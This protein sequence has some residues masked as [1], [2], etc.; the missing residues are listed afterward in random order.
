MAGDDFLT[1]TTL[2]I[3][4]GM[5]ELPIAQLVH[6]LQRVPGVLFAE[7]NAAGSRVVVAHDAGVPTA[8]LLNAASALG[9][10]AKFVGDTR[11]AAVRIAGAL[12]ASRLPKRNVVIVAAI[13]VPVALGVSILIPS[14]AGNRWLLPAVFIALWA[15]VFAQMMWGPKR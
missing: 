12:P 3:D 10:Q 2:Q 13:L 14:F 7:I 8:S 9:L 15:I 1:R 11:T 5:A 6:G 4:T